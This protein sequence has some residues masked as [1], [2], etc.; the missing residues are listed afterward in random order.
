MQAL[1]PLTCPCCPAQMLMESGICS[2]I[3]ENLSWS[4]KKQVKQYVEES[5]SD[6]K[7]W[8]CTVNN[9]GGRIPNEICQKCSQHYCPKCK[10]KQHFLDSC[11]SSQRTS[12][13]SDPS[14]KTILKCPRC[15][16][17]N[18]LNRAHN[19]MKNKIRCGNQYCEVGLCLQHKIIWGPNHE[20]YH[21]L[22]DKL[23][24]KEVGC[25]SC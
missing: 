12:T 22:E 17:L 7:A 21:P 18:Q 19:Q 3:F 10:E 25:A 14:P 23:L 6:I 16:Y 20:S 11:P 13:S 15:G 2:T 9:C 24:K 1:E 4:K 5:K 8:I